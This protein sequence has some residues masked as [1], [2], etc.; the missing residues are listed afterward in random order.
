MKKY[1]EKYLKNHWFRYSDYWNKEKVEI[2]ERIDPIEKN[3][4]KKAI[5]LTKREAE[6]LCR[7][8]KEIFERR[9]MMKDAANEA[10]YN[11]PDQT[12]KH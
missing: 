5:Y 4:Y 7:F 6:A 8:L 1:Y 2:A 11:I 12:D 9:R 10:F 3:Q